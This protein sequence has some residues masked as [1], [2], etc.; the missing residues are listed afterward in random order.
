MK[1]AAG[2]SS[3]ILIFESFVVADETSNGSLSTFS[4]EVLEFQESEK[5]FLTD[6]L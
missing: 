3:I 2:L 6:V 4:P 5:Y 1:L